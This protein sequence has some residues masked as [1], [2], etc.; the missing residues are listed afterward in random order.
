MSHGNETV[1]K[2]INALFC[3]NDTSLSGKTWCRGNHYIIGL[4]LIVHW[5]VYCLLCLNLLR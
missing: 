4:Q 2:N 3:H 5:C 1:L